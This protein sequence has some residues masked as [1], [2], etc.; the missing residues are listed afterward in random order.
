MNLLRKVIAVSASAVVV[1]GGATVSAQD[2]PS[3][4]VELINPVAPGGGTDIFLRMLSSTSAEHFEGDFVVESK[5]GGQG[6]VSMNYLNNRPADGH[7]LLAFT[8]GQLLALAENRGPFKLEDLAPVVVGTIDPMVLIAKPGAFEGVDDLIAQ[9]SERALMG[10][11]TSA[12]TLEWMALMA[13]AEAAGM[14]EPRYLPTQS[15]GEVVLNVIG[16][17]IEVGVGNLTEVTE[18]VKNGELD[19]LVVMSDERSEALPDVPT[20][21]ESGADVSLAQVRGL[22]ALA[23]TPEDRI[24]ML[25]SAFL[26]GM[27]SEQ[28]QEYLR[29]NGLDSSSIGDSEKWGQM[30]QDIT[31]RMSELSQKFSPNQSN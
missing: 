12:G 19:A 26:E 24:E 20:A 2:Y 30:M 16:G 7:T 1:L 15:G 9:G 28:Y 29:S 27:N 17:D 25:E 4:A 3:E 23:D 21:A 22:V 31:G 18:R 13:F 10:G 8:S 11:G 14:Q 5:E 6:I